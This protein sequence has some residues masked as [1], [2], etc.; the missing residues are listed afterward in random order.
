MPLNIRSD[1]VNRIGARPA[2][3]LAA[4]K[5]FYDERSGAP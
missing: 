5:A 4:D 3:G 2:I 1:E